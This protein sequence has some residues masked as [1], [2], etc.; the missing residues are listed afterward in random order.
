MSEVNDAANPEAIVTRVSQEN[1]DY[2]ETSD[3]TEVHAAIAREHREPSFHAVPVPLWLL[4]LCGVVIFCAGSYL[5]MFHGGF[6][7]DVFNERQTSPE[8]FFTTK[9]GKQSVD[10]GKL[11]VSP[12]DL[13]KKL[14]AL[15]CASCHQASGQGVPGQ[16]PPLVQSEFVVGS[17]SRLGLIVLKG[18]Q[19]PI[20]VHGA[21]YNGA[22]PAQEKA[23]DNKKLAAILTYIRSE[24]GNAAPAVAPE[25]IAE[26]RKQFADKTTSTTEAE[27]LALPE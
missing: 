3:I 13:G 25:Q 4:V 16:F 20:T 21:V 12:R 19:G 6:R 14:F 2:R 23:L 10:Q 9:A 5:S 7:G 18:L 8:L 17:P 22:M 27:L 11:E 24:W 1:L 26:F 15:N